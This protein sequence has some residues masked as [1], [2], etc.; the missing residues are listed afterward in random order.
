MCGTKTVVSIVIFPLHQPHHKISL[1]VDNELNSLQVDDFH[2]H[3][4]NVEEDVITCRFWWKSEMFMSTNLS[5]EFI[6][7][8]L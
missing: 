6:V 3:Q 2:L 4:S 5:V 8:L 1:L 7:L